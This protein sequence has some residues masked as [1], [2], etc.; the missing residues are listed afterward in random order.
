MMPFELLEEEFDRT[1]TGVRYSK[2]P[3]KQREIRMRHAY[4]RRLLRRHKLEESAEPKKSVPVPRPLDE[5]PG[6]ADIY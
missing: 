1:A 2:I 4:N 5:H 3:L 6:V